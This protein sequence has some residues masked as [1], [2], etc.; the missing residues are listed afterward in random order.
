MASL[1]PNATPF[2]PL[3]PSSG[4]PPPP[5]RPPPGPSEFVRFSTLAEDM[6]ILVISFVAQAPFELY[7][8]GLP[9]R[10]GTLTH[11]LNY[12]CKE[13]Q[14]ICN[15]NTLWGMAIARKR[16]NKWCPGFAA[17]LDVLANSNELSTEKKRFINGEMKSKINLP[18]FFM[19]SGLKVG[20]TV[21]W[22][23][24]EP[25]V[26]GSLLPP[27]KRPKF[28]YLPN[29]QVVEGAQLFL[30]E[31]MSVNLDPRG[32]WDVQLK[33][34]K[35]FICEG[36]SVQESNYLHFVK[37]REITDDAENKP[38]STFEHTVAMVE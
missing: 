20:Y 19:R 37:G 30:C 9:L 23:E 27:D 38:M 10:Y 24:E 32:E 22:G 25:M 33:A 28:F 4:L 35:K 7:E 12:V 16:E 36:F 1:N 29:N 3:P 14:K 15:G 6:Q 13:W 11:N 2:P 17:V 34:V 18:T 8:D 26:D 5:P 21:D 31:A